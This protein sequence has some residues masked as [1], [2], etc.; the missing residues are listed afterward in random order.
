MVTEQGIVQ[1][2]FNKKAMV[3]VQPSSACATCDSRDACDVLSDR[4]ILIEVA[5]DID[6]KI[7]DLVEISVSTHSLL[8]LSLLIYLLPVAALIVGACAGGTWARFF[9]M[10]SGL[11]SIL[12]GV[13]AM[14]ITFL[15]LKRLNR[16]A[17]SKGEYSPR[18]TRI[19]VSAPSARPDDN[20]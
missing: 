3:S 9:H 7:D 15:V 5:N 6:A 20:I 19:L 11:A 13:F 2:T 1:K 17:E 18:M 10:Q 12:G 4:D 16:A 14:C 8:K